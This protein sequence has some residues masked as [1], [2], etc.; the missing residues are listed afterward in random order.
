MSIGF[1]CISQSSFLFGRGQLVTPHFKGFLRGSLVV[2]IMQSFA[3]E[4]HVTP[5]IK[6]NN[7]L[8]QKII[9]ILII[10][11][12]RAQIQTLENSLN[13][14]KYPQKKPNHKVFFIYYSLA[15]YNTIH[16][17]LT[18]VIYR[19]THLIMVDWFFFFFFLI[20]WNKRVYEKNSENQ[21]C[22]WVC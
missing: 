1:I 7:N 22:V 6:E 21:Y 10:K 20:Q 9:V 18:F 19:C 2:F 16:I 14:V 11:H 17:L 4:I 15:V 12:T 3:H 5:L 8:S 13:T